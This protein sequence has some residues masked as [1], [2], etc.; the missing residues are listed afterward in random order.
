[1]VAMTMREEPEPG[2]GM[3]EPSSQRALAEGPELMRLMGADPDGI[4]LDD[5]QEDVPGRDRRAAAQRG[6]AVH[7][8][9]ARTG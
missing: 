9:A 8:R 1:M 3:G 2:V 4:T 7:A 6:D 5:A